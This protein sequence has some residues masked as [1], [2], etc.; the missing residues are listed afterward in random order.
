MDWIA[1]DEF[2]LDAG[3]PTGRRS[4][5]VFLVRRPRPQNHRACC[6]HIDGR[7]RLP[8]L[9]VARQ[10][11]RLPL[12]GAAGSHDESPTSTASGDG[13]SGNKTNR[14]RDPDAARLRALFPPIPDH[15]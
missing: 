12:R 11:K 10:P 13:T 4:R 3:G 2:E 6:I 5:D 8:R 1:S 14:N 7:P 15:D 9:L